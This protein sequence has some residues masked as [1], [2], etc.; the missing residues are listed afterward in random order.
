MSA[1]GATRTLRKAFHARCTRCYAFVQSM[2][3]AWQNSRS[4]IP[5]EL[6]PLIGRKAA[7]YATNIG[8]R[9]IGP[10]CQ[11]SRFRKRLK[12]LD[13]QVR[14]SQLVRAD[15]AIVHSGKHSARWVARNRGGCAVRPLHPHRESHR[16]KRPSSAAGRRSLPRVRP[17]SRHHHI[18]QSPAWSSA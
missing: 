3:D 18:A 10:D 16:G 15:G 13:V 1:L 14:N 6:R 11:R 17:R 4:Q 8:I 7:V 12:Q 9:Q 2:E 5:D